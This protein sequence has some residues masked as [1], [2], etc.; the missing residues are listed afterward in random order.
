[1]RHFGGFESTKIHGSGTDIIETTGHL[2]QWRDDID[3]L[4][5]AGIRDLRYSAPWHRIEARFGRFDFTWMD[6][7]M[8]HMRERG[9]TP[10]IDLLH[11]TS[12]PDWLYGG[13]ANPSFPDLFRRF[14]VRFAERYPWID[15][16]TLFNEPLATSILCAYSGVWYPHRK[17]DADFVA[18]GLNIARA[19]Q[20]ADKAIREVRPYIHVY[21]DT[22]EYHATVDPACADEVALL[23][24]R[25]FWIPDLVLGW[26]NSGHPFYGYLVQHGLKDSD[27]ERFRDDPVNIDILGLD[28][29]RH[30]EMEWSV[31]E[32]GTFRVQTSGNPR[33]FESVARDYIERYSLPVMLSETNVRGTV[34]ERLTWLRE[35]HGQCERLMASGV[36]FRGFCWYPTIDSTDWSNLVTRS[37]GDVD[38]QGIW[39]LE[40]GERRHSVLSHWYGR[41][42]RGESRARD[43]P[44]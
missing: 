43:I 30:S 40:N 41:L 29:Y 36:D 27:L 20:R 3:L 39:Y 15:H 35:M 25:R 38:P 33:T 17:S 16:Y 10:V 23:N 8:E 28:Y 32:D 9:M 44:A 22:C 12:F 11:H 7:P 37:S 6:L 31:A 5:N 24:Y 19:I 26:I 21:V 13:F 2:L 14:V 18:M 1:M 4:Y 42:A 34:N